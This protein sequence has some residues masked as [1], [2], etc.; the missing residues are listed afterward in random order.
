RDSHFDLAVLLQNSFRAALL[1]RTS[2]VRAVVGYPT[3]GRRVLL[4]V[5]VP[6]PRDYKSNHQVFYYLGIAYK[7]ERMFVEQ[8]CVKAEAEGGADSGKNAEPR[9]VATRAEVERAIDILRD[10]GIRTAGP[11]S[12]RIVALNPG[13]TNSRAKR[14]L[15]ERF[16]Q[17]A[18]RLATGDGLQTVII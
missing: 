5:P 2:R 8:V 15:A 6:F 7:L 1:A 17:T 9:L 18:D 3:D 16:A 10:S 13:A 12:A 14:W 4:T 11:G